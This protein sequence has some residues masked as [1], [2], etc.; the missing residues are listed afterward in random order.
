MP[1]APAERRNATK[2]ITSGNCFS[3]LSLR[4]VIE[5]LGHW[6]I[7]LPEP[8]RRASISISFSAELT[9]HVRRRVRRLLNRLTRE[10]TICFS[11]HYSA[12]RVSKVCTRTRQSLL[13][14][15]LGAIAQRPKHTSFALMIDT[16]ATQHS[17]I[18][19]TLPPPSIEVRERIQ[20]R[21][22]RAADR[23]IETRR[24]HAGAEQ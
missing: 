8:N 21:R 2:V 15:W 1:A 12:R 6:C 22:R 7:S 16:R 23:S 18:F 5:S 17:S 13:F 10:I 9:F 19:S 11:L 20:C 14:F 24:T 3:P 4:Y